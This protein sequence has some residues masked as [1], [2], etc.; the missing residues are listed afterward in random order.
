MRDSLSR[1][2]NRVPMK[3]FSTTTH[4]D[5]LSRV[6]NDVSTLQQALANSI[7][8]MMAAVVQFAGC[9]LMMVIT[10]WRMALAAIGVTLLGF[11]AMRLSFPS[12]KGILRRDRGVSEN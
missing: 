11:C 10:E 6:T 7:P 9:L 5:I 8:N 1:K 12:L 4:G 3:C 2:I